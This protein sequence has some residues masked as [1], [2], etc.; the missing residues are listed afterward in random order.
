MAII[1]NFKSL[2]LKAFFIGITSFLFYS[3]ANIVPPNGGLKDTTPPQV[4]KCEPE[5]QSVK[6]NSRIIRIA[7]D[8]YI[9]LNNL[10]AQ[11][12]ISPPQN[13]MPEITVRGKFINIKLLD[14][15][16]ENTTYNFYFGNA[17]VDITEANPLSN[18]QY[19]FSTGDFLD[20]MSVGGYVY[21]ALDLKPAEEVYVMLYDSLIDSIPYLQRPVYI[22]KTD[23]TGRFQLNNLRNINYKIFALSD[24]N[25]NLLFDLKTEK[26]AFIDSIIKPDFFENKRSIEKKSDSLVLK[27]STLKDTSKIIQKPPVSYN[28]YMFEQKDSTQHV[29][30]KTL[31][32]KGLLSVFFKYPVQNFK[33]EYPKIKNHKEIIN[34]EFNKTFD[35]L[36]IWV[37]DTTL[38]SL[39][40]LIYQSDTVLDTLNLSVIPRVSKRIMV[41]KL[42]ISSNITNNA[43]FDYFNYP[44]F[45]FNNPLASINKDSIVFTE[46]SVR[47]IPQFVY[48]DS[49]HRYLQLTNNLKE[50]ASY[51]LYFPSN[52]FTD[53]FNHPHDSLR[54]S[55][56]TKKKEDYGK[57]VLKVKLP[58]EKHQYI[59]MLLDEKEKV[60]KQEIIKT[61]QNI[62]FLNMNPA[63]FYVKVIYDENN[64]GKWTSGN[65]LKKKQPEK[66]FKSKGEIV[67]RANWDVELEVIVD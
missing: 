63:K 47:I 26:I 10:N 46:D 65:Y 28:M 17:I 25:S 48:K 7:F 44:V 15:L 1:F 62:E 11:L 52:S 56:K 22:T 32:R 51:N 61:S 9:K 39:F 50:I 6:F 64:D 41:A 60:F 5:N 57:L 67:T 38:D 34:E 12:M 24:A 29:I 3:C 37:K 43:V 30:K 54:L 35:S 2:A 59:I 4:I 19:A 27:D 45:E 18:Y 53:I 66:V 36:K 55:F 40:A 8:E 20:S 23:K 33:I 13:N 21:N 42:L 58:D 49:T 14:T 16:S 31:E